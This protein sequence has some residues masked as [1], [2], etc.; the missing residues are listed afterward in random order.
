MM[1]GKTVSF[2]ADMSQSDYAEEKAVN[3]AYWNEL[4]HIN[5]ESEGHDGYNVAGLLRGER[6][7]HPIEDG[8]LGPVDGLSLLHLQCHFGVD[9]LI[10]AQ[11][12]AAVTGLDY[13]P[14]AIAKARELAE[15]AGLGATFVEGD[16]Y[17]APSLVEGQFDLVYTGWGALNWLPDIERW[18]AVVAHFVKPGGT[19][20][21]AEW[22]PALATLDDEQTEGPATVAYSYFH[23]PNPLRWETE[24]A[25]SDGASKLESKTNYEWI[26]PIG[27]IV[28]ALIK[29]GLRLDFLHEHDE[30]AWK[31]LPIM[32]P[33]GHG[34]YRLPDGH[35]SFPL[36]FS[37]KATKPA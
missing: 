17:D 7:L 3:R 32:V 36:S 2:E 28:T 23:K 21:I 14:D 6:P 9:S 33:G 34:Q 30:V 20:Y 31:A 25:Y 29:A 4:V 26:H 19:F 37:I 11:R 15:K 12:G 27:E 35:P 13:S 8:E 5:A 22:H 1:S 10:L 24:V 18:A 16:L